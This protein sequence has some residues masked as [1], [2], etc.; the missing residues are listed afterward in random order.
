MATIRSTVLPAFEIGPAWEIARLFPNQGYIS[1]G[2]Y[3]RLTD[4]TRRMAEY[5]DGRIEVLPM[6]TEEHQEIV[7][8]LVN[9]FRAFILPQRLGWAIMSPFRVRV[10]ES[11]Y[12]EPDVA[13]LSRRNSQSRDNRYWSAADLVVEVVSE[14]D[15]KRD[16]VDKRRDYAAAGIAEYWIVDPRTQS[17]VVLQLKRGKYA[18]HSEA[19]RTGQ[20]RSALLKGFT[21]DVAAVFAAGK[22]G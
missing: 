10:A 16:L 22:N 11:I 6:P 2:D 9:L 13:F 20:V 8:F 19:K 14:D 4:T 18:V 17:I 5:I 1:E 21:A 7:L 12:R 15:R 3:L